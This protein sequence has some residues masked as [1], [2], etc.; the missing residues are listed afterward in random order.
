M[1]AL[2]RAGIPWEIVYK[3]PS[4]SGLWAATRANLGVT[5]RSSYLV[6]SGLHP[7][8]PSKIDLIDLPDLGDTEVNIHYF[9]AALSPKLLEMVRHMERLILL[10]LESGG[11]HPI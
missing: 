6:P 5:I 3:S 2:N 10:P 11:I 8:Q 9:E 4:L 7:V 1:E